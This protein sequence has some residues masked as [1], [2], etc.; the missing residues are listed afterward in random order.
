MPKAY[1]DQFL[2]LLNINKKQQIPTSEEKK[3]GDLQNGGPQS[4]LQTIHSAEATI[5]TSVDGALV[6]V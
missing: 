5:T 4:N 2:F 3:R 6:N 1:R